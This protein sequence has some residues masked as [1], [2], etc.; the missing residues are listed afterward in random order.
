MRSV[1]ALASAA[2]ILAL[3]AA[4]SD[5]PEPLGPDVN[6]PEV[7]GSLVT[8]AGSGTTGPINPALSSSKCM[9]VKGINTAAGTPMQIWD[10]TK[11]NNQQFKWLS[12]GQIQVYGSMC[13]SGGTGKDGD[14]VVIQACA[15]G[16]A[17]QWSATSA[18]GIKGINSKCVMVNGGSTNGTRLVLASC[19]SATNQQWNVG[20]SSTPTP[21]PPPPSSGGSTDFHTIAAG[22]RPRGFGQG[23]YSLLAPASGARAWYV[24]TSGNDASAGTSGAPLRTIIKAAQLAHA[25]DVVTIGNGTYSG[26]VVVRNSGSSSAP[27]VFQAAQRGGVVL[28]DG[29]ASFRPYDWSGGVQQTGELYIT[30]RGLTFR[31]YASNA[32]TSSGPNFAAAVK[33]ARGW[34]IEDCLLDHAGNTGIQIEGSY[35][36][37]IKTTLQYTYFEAL[38]AW[39]SGTAS[40]PSDA[41]YKPLD[42]IQIIDVNLNNN[43]VMNRAPSSGGVA[44]YSS[45]F[46]NTRGTVIDNM[47]S[48]SNNGPGFW[49][50]TQNS[51]FTVKNSYFHD[52]KNISGTAGTGRGLNVEANWGP[53][54]IQNNV[55]SNNARMG[56]GIT[57][58]QGITMRNNLI[59]GSPRCIELTNDLS[60]VSRFP[61]KSITLKGTVCK[62]WTDFAGLMTVG[63]APAFTSPSQMGIMADSTTYDPPS[64]SSIYAW[65]ENK[66]IGAAYSI[67]D[68]QHKFGWETHG[69]KAAVTWP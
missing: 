57:A 48:Y 51:N 47:E 66:T 25:G 59:A 43:Y 33:A 15:S 45:K 3:T 63:G 39:A 40:S 9:D 37:V 55:F 49:F 46:L 41:N 23:T 34:K 44:D 31:N 29:N 27:I 10:C 8:F 65:W 17:Q 61:L 69:K 26:S 67:T 68:E 52:N 12:T 50:D 58:S 1:L 28:T 64:T 30:L 60:R 32:I 16:T 6:V 24:S 7:T 56:L 22:I 62:G 11:R 2:A 20:G 5:R 54:L 13:L 53:G 42:G 36:T 14:P 35:V 4:C 21:P 19:S 18:N 38:S